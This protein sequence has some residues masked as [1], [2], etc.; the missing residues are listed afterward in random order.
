MAAQAER[1]V[2]LNP[3]ANGDR[4]AVVREG[5]ISYLPATRVDIGATHAGASG[6][7]RYTRR[8]SDG[9][10]YVTGPTIERKMFRSTDGGWSWSS[11]AYEL[12]VEQF[13]PVQMPLDSETGWVGAFTILRDDTFLMNVMPSNHR[14]NTESYIARSD[15]RGVTWSVERM[16]LPLGAHRSVA[17]GNADMIE[18][19]DGTLLLTMDLFFYVEADEQDNLPVEHRGVFAHVLRSHDRGRTWPEKSI[20]VLHGAEVHLLELPTGSLMAASRKQRNVYLPGDP[21]DLET[22]MRANGYNPEYTGFH[23][24]IDE[25]AAVVKSVVVSESSDAGRT[26]VN[27]RRVT[28][29]EQCSGELTLLADDTTL[30]LTYDSRYHDRFA[31]AGVRARVSYDLGDSWEPEEYIL[32]EGE[33][34]PGA[35]AMPDGRIMTI[36]PYQHLGPI[37]AVHWAPLPKGP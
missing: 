23:E 15:D 17:A 30:V 29:Y 31:V 34:Y 36:C 8:S 25:H 14:R 22:A 11:H 32:G 21:A 4:I 16:E 35:I 13:D 20:I 18:L 2:D 37:Q 7:C 26:W 28:G 6:S 5:D 24:P 9:D 33:N 12:G 27:E 3:D 10:L 19:A 1:L